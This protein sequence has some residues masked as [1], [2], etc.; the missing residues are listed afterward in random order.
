MNKRQQK[1][2]S[3]NIRTNRKKL[4]ITQEQLAEQLGYTK[5]TISNWEAGKHTPDY[6]DL[7]KMAGIFGVPLNDLLNNSQPKSDCSELEFVEIVPIPYRINT[8][9]I[10]FKDNVNDL[11]TAW[12]YDMDY[13][14][15]MFSGY[16]CSKH[17]SYISFK[18]SFF[19]D[20]EE[21]VNI[22]R[23]FMDSMQIF[24]HASSVRD[25]KAMI[26]NM[27]KFVDN[28]DSMLYED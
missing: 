22:T 21:W 16:D 8:Y 11:W 20:A 19:E 14:L 12:I 23:D 2:L 10:F 26:E 28:P 6:A 24:D 25:A 5:Q 18:E 17:V 9:A 15:M 1:S 27:E 4:H 3:L 13:P 7:E